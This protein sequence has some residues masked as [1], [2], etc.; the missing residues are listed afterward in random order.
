MWFGWLAWMTARGMR[1]VRHTGL[2][3]DLDLVRAT[4]QICGMWIHGYDVPL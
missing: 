1:F 2:Q 3:I 4:E